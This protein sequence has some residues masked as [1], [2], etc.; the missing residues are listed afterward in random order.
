MYDILQDYKQVNTKT[1]GGRRTS[2]TFGVQL[3][4]DLLLIISGG[5]KSTECTV[6]SCPE[7]SSAKKH[8]LALR[9]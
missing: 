2:R 9:V 3:H 5:G 8:S 4:S 7:A 1:T 6:T